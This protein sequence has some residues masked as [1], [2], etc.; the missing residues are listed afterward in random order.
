MTTLRAAFKSL[1]RSRRLSVAAILCVGLGAAA[2]ASVGTFVSATLLRPLPFPSSERLVRIWF[3]EGENPRV[4]LSIPEIGDLASLG[5]FDQLL[6]TARSRF[7]GIFE[8]GAERVRGEGVTANYF[9]VLGLQART[10][11]LF[12]PDDYRADAPP[13]AVVSSRAWVARYGADPQIVGRTLRTDRKSFTIVG[14][15]P[16]GF[17]G[18]VEDDV[19][20]VWMPLTHYEPAELLQNREERPAWAIGRLREGVG[21]EAARAEVEALTRTLRDEH[22]NIYPRMRLAVEPMGENWRAGLR[23]R[24]L[25]LTAASGILLLVA[26]INVAGLLLA[27]VLDRRREMAVRAA[28]GAGRGR[29]V[30]QLM[31]EALVLASLGGLVGFVAA[32]WVLEGFLLMTP[33]ALPS[34]LSLSLDTRALVYSF[35]AL[36]AAGV[37]AGCAPALVGSRVSPGEALREG[38]RAAVSG[39]REGRWGAW[40]VAAETAL[41]LVLLVVAGLLLRSWER[42]ERMDVGFRTEGIARLA[43]SFSRLDLRDA[44][45]LPAEYERLRTTLASHPGV[46][47][48]ALVSP[49]LPPW[50]G[51]RPRVRFQSPDPSTSEEGLVVGVHAADPALFRVLGIPLAAGRLIDASDGP[52]SGR[53]A[54]VSHGLAERLGGLE[55]AIGREITL[56]ADGDVP[57]QP[58][59][60]VGVVDNVAWDGA[61][62]QDTRRYIRYADAADARGGREDLYLS[63]DQYPSRRVSIAALTSGDAARLIDSLRRRLGEIAPTSAVHW[64]STMAEEVASEFAPSRFYALLVLSFSA[65]ALLLTAIGVFALLAHTVARRTSEIGLRVALGASPR[66]VLRLVAGGGLAPLAAGVGGGL[67]AAAGGTRWLS[68]LL[69]D[70]SPRDAAAFAGAALVVLLAALPATL[71]PARRA[72]SLDPMQALRDE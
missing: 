23:P 51:H 13:V 27:R 50:D 69:Y 67:L 24:G 48:V 56:P 14:V 47:A 34:Y 26:A 46:D 12:G 54:L 58:V 15:L 59:R 4:H 6:G 29:L 68:S 40:L 22:P 60:V 35:L 33:V 45:R 38:G 17:A 43:I 1:L 7:V 3:Q 61:A 66:D 53:V 10:G 21:L 9:E 39:R 71:L 2:T 70:V 72:T 5:S 8:G 49:T 62:D 65:S 55:G 44:A 32:P 19:V 52:A 31:T 64:T 41:T 20:E 28:L 16:A 18:T 63:L 36:A 42:L 37:V 57:A 30:G 11:R 25:M